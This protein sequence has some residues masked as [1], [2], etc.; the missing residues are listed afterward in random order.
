MADSSAKSLYETIGL[1][2]VLLGLVFVGFEIRQNTQ[3]VKGATIQ[4]LAEMSLEIQLT[5]MQMPE[6]R[7]AFRMAKQIVADDVVLH[8]LH[9]SPDLDT[10]TYTLAGA[11]DRLR[12]RGFE[13]VTP[14]RAPS[15]PA[16]G[17]TTRAWP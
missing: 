3:A 15:R 8:G 10:C 2:A 4:G 13:A 11:I 14:R 1:V 9:V 7:E 17:R 12:A 6:L 5:G 16:V